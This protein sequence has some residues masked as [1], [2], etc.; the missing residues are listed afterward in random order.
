MHTIVVSKIKMKKGIRYKKHL[1]CIA[2][3]KQ[4]SGFLTAY[5]HNR[6]KHEGKAMFKSINQEWGGKE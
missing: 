1:Q 3:A 6:K 2:C 5:N 4:Y